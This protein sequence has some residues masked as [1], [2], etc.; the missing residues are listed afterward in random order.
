MTHST[1]RGAAGAFEPMMPQN[2]TATRLLS[3]AAVV[4]LLAACGGGNAESP[5]GEAPPP[6]PVQV[7]AVGSATVDSALIESGPV[8]SGTLMAERRAE[9]RPLVSGTV[10]AVPVRE[11]QAVRAGAM[12]VV[13]DT[14]VLAD[15]VRS[16]RL[17]VQSAEMA[18]A[19]AQRNF[20]RSTELERAGAIA[21]RD[22]EAA[23]DMQAQASAVL[24]DARARLAAA[25]QQ[26]GH[27]VVRAPFTGVVAELP[28]NA[29]DV[30]QPGGEPLATVVDPSTLEL[31]ASVPAANLSTLRPGARVEFTAAAQPGR[32]F[33]GTI[34]RV[35]PAV[36]PTTGQLRLYVRVP[37]PDRALA[38]GLFAEGR[39][40]VESVRGL[41]IPIAALDAR[42]T[43]P[44]VKRVR[45]GVVELAEVTLGV[46]DELAER[47]QVT[48]GLTLGDTV[49]VGAALGTPEGATVRLAPRDR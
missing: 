15:Q 16:A 47:V 25:Q 46:R 41:A 45:G 24:Q 35:N 31:E 37:N 38:A 36:D 30:V 42:A 8:L 23:R 49:L 39:V 22:L 27:A 2:R 5:D 21:T 40:A 26:L 33:R 32:V 18:A 44:T 10:L 34:A 1:S 7:S 48:A 9:L 28:V 6:P 19:T 12:L 13:V 3:H 20:D 14:T 29:G 11:G 43:V 4:L 17:A